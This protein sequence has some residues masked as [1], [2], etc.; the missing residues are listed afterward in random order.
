MLQVC[1]GDEPLRLRRQGSKGS[2]QARSLALRRMAAAVRSYTKIPSMAGR[3]ILCIDDLSADELKGM[4]A[5]A[6]DLKAAGREDR[7][8]VSTVS[9]YSDPLF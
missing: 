6:G 1:E 5:L 9:A 2:R 7:T 4:L 8:K 3:S